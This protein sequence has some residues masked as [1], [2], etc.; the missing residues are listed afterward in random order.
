MTFSGYRILQ[1]MPAAADWRAVFADGNEKGLVL[2]TAL[3]GWALVEREDGTRA[4]VG[5]DATGEVES[6]EA[7]ENFLAYAAPGQHS[8]QWHQE[9]ARYFAELQSRVAAPGRGG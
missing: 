3:A 1:I 8:S 6:C 2:E 5:C 4:I 9:A 7:V